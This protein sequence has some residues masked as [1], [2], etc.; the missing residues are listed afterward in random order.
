MERTLADNPPFSSS[1]L[2]TADPKEVN[3]RLDAF[4]KEHLGAEVEEV[5]FFRLGTGAAFGLILGSGRR[6]FLK[7]HPP[8]RNAE[9][10]RAVRRVQTHLYRQGFP[11][12]NSILGPLPFGVGLATVDEFVDGGAVSPTATTRGSGVGWRRSSPAR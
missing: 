12:P 3:H 7:A 2:G 4:C 11:C 5:L 9:Y 1:I 10:L 6:V 8:V